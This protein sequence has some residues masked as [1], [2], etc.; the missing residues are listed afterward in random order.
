MKKKLFTALV[1]LIVSVSLFAGSSSL[2]VG[3]QA[4]WGFDILKHTVTGKILS[5]TT[6]KTA[7][8]R[9]NGVQLNLTA[10]CDF[11]NSWGMRLGGGIAYKGK[12]TRDGNTDGKI[13]SGIAFDVTA[14]GKYSKKVN[15]ELTVSSLIGAELVNGYVSKYDSEKLD[16]EMKNTAFGLNLSLE[17]AY[18]IRKN[19]SFTLG[20]SMGWFFVNRGEAFTSDSSSISFDGS[21]F[22]SASKKTV[23]FLIR[24][25][26]GVLYSL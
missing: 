14:Q 21:T 17:G 5:S 26:L 3:A 7:V 1:A 13:D 11:G 16:S 24:P 18:R 19:V 15:K 10:D 6:E 22:A 2:T 20:C 9:N 23:S 12:A 25:Y 4:G 8:Y